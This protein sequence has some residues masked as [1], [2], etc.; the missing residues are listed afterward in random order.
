MKI[1][2]LTDAFP[3]EQE[4]GAGEVVSALANQLAK[5]K[6]EIFVLSTTKDFAGNGWQAQGKVKIKRIFSNYHPRWSNLLG[7]CNPLIL[8]RLRRVLKEVKPDIVHAHNV[9]RYF[10]YCSLILA[11]KYAR[12]VFL[13]LHDVNPV[14]AG[15]LVPTPE[16][17]EKGLSQTKPSWWRVSLWREMKLAKKRFNPWRRFIVRK[18]IKKADDIFAVSN[19]FRQ[20]LSVNGIEA[21]T[22]YNGVD[23]SFWGESTREQSFQK[24]FG[25]QNNVSYL[26]F[27]GRLSPAKGTEQLLRALKL[28]QRKKPNVGLL[29]A[30]SGERYISKLK[31][32]IKNDNLRN[33]IFTGWLP[34]SE[35]KNAYHSCCLGVVLSLC[36]ETFGL[37]AA[38]AMTAG[39]PIIAS[40]LGGLKEIVISGENGFLVNPYRTQELADKILFLLEDE[41]RTRK[42]SLAA[43]EQIKKFALAKQVFQTEKAYQL[44]V[45][46]KKQ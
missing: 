40:P 37:I 34:P 35:L 36:F 39:L 14:L 23:L 3:P 4:G 45:E 6:H 18:I 46:Q 10:S 20:F 16:E 17:L 44:A 28:V 32:K 38:S 33:I 13:T 15:K 9:S 19:A 26:F 7:V 5:R 12:A 30:G 22:I 41:D 11:K 24:K 8:L 29:I 31:E 25:L 42:F 21:R 1:L 2:F 43:K 27:G